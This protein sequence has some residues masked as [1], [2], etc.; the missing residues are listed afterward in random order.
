MLGA[1]GNLGVNSIEFD[2]LCARARAEFDP[3]LRAE[4]YADLQTNIQT[5][6][7]VIIP[8]FA[9]FLQAISTRIAEPAT[10]GNLWPMDNA[11]FAER[12]W[13]S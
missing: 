5:A 9:N 1:N 11:R 2:D 13:L 12:W 3:N 10:Q 4:L 6:G 7:P 8:A